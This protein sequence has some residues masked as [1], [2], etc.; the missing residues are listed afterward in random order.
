MLWDAAW[1]QQNVIEGKVYS[2]HIADIMSRSGGASGPSTTPGTGAASTPGGSTSVGPTPSGST[3]SGPTPG[4]STPGGST[5]TKSPTVAAT[6]P[7]PGGGGGAG[8]FV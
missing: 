4:G 7:S 3:P 2:D 1:D 5:P 8:M 6:P